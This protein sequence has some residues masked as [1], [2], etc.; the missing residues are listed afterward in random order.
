MENKFL[1]DLSIKYGLSTSDTSNLVDVIYQ[2]GFDDISSAEFAKVA[3]FICE[4][5]ILELPSEE[6]MEKLRLKGFTA[7]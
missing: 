5:E 3:N 4:N 6:L 7:S 2:A 1:I